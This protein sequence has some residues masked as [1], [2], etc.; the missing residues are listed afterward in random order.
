[1]L[2]FLFQISLFTISCVFNFSKISMLK[3]VSYL[4]SFKKLKNYSF[5]SVL[6]GVIFS[7]VSPGILQRVADLI[8]WCQVT[9][10]VP[11]NLMLG[12]TPRLT[13]IPF[14]GWGGGDGGRRNTPGRVMLQKMEIN[15]NLMGHV[16]RRVQEL[17][18]FVRTRES[19]HT[20]AAAK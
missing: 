1:M 3:T 13:G 7:Q 2:D 11:V 8:R 12:V 6:V 16:D 4:S 19:P 18:L 15:T 9:V 20:W 17:P 5:R 14:S 10:T